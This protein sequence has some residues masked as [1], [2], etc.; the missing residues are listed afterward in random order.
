MGCPLPRRGCSPALP[1]IGGSGGGAPVPLLA[2]LKH[3]LLRL[4]TGQGGHAYAVAILEQ[5]IL[6][7]PRPSPG[8]EGV[9]RALATFRGDREGLHHRDPRKNLSDG[10][11]DAAANLID[12]LREALAPL[13]SLS[14][15]R[16]PFRNL[17]AAHREVVA[18]LSD[19]G[20][21]IVAAFAGE[22]GTTL[23]EAFEVATAES[24]ATSLTVPPGDYA[25][26]FRAAFADVVVRRPEIAGVRV[27]I[28]GP[29]ESRLQTF[30]R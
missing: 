25:E 5:A 12:R 1:P 14:N 9:K 20:D 23:A 24:A 11:L 15:V 30:D 7:G 26:L 3:H 13:E 4:G 17:M 28:L 6:R 19:A 27:R 29:L 18:R 22:D 21:G 2:L 8:T 10:Q 16:H